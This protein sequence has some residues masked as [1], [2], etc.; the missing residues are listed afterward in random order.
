MHRIGLLIA[1]HNRREKTLACLRHAFGQ[2]GLGERFRLDC[3]LVD[4]GSS[5]GT[6]D[7]VRQEFPRV[8]VF[9]GDGSL[10]WNRAMHWAMKEAAAADPDFY[11]WLNDDTQLQKNACST[12]L[13]TY[14]AVSEDGKRSALVVGA[15]SDPDTGE[16]T[17]GGVVRCSRWHPFRYQQVRPQSVPALCDTMNGNCVL[18][19][20]E[21]ARRVGNL[22]PA[23]RHAIGDTD[24]GLRARARGCSLWLTP[25]FVGTC[26]R[27][28]AAEGAW[29]KSLPLRERWKKVCSPKGLPPREFLV[30]ARRH[31]GVLWPA[32]WALPYLRLIFRPSA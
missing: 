12:L 31:G 22:E 15:I 13:D 32:F 19:P 27:N 10:F 28:P 29:H 11:L 9:K 23:F 24:Y 16:A 18:I 6:A 2:D 20:R 7:H 5:D 26:R 3:Y 21:V 8:Q 17:Y 25:G 4:D 1:S 30:F 14:D